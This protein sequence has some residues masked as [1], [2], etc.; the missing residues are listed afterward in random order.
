VCSSDLS[1]H[2]MSG[3]T[4]SLKYDEYRLYGHRKFGR[5]D[6]TIDL[7]SVA[8]AEEINGIKT[9]YSGSLACGYAVTTRAR[10]GADVEYSR[11]P[12][13]D[14]DVRGLVKLVYNFDIAPSAKGRK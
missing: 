4:D 8:Y 10:I 9:A 2:R 3:V 14:K 11:N 12:F 7:F 1:M 5:A 6:L 13:F